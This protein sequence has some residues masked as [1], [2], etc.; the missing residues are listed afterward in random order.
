MDSSRP[1]KVL[2]AD[3]RDRMRDKQI[4]GNEGQ[5]AEAYYIGCDK[6]C[7]LFV[8]NVEESKYKM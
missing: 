2:K 5:H 8:H 7:F 1:D 6:Y 4:G 3:N